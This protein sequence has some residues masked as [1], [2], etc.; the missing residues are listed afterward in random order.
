MW[1]KL[2]A[3]QQRQFEKTGPTVYSRTPTVDPPADMTVNNA[4]PI[5]GQRAAVY[6]PLDEEWYDGVILKVLEAKR[7][8]LLR[9]DD[10]LEEA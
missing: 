6:W 5:V 9:Y 1:P 10:G 7:S 2:S 8:V 4:V 3:Q